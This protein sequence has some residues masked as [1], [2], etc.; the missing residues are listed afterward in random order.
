VKKST[1]KRLTLSRETLLGLDND[2]LLARVAGG[3]S[4]LGTCNTTCTTGCSFCTN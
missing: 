1:M 3:D 4:Q 2:S